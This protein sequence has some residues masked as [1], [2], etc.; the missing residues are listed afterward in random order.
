MIQSAVDMRYLNGVQMSLNGPVISHIFF[1]DDTLIFLKADKK[2]CT[3]LVQ[4]LNE[5]RLASGQ[6][7]NIQ[8]S[9]V[10]FSANISTDVSVELMAILGMNIVFD[11]GTYLGVLAVW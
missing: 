11:P 9:N 10:F 8:K 5:Y 2:N 4:L 7:V 1:T 6:A 3:N